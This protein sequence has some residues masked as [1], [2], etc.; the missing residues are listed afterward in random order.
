MTAQHGA[1]P[2]P[3]RVRVIR[4]GF[5]RSA[6]TGSLAPDVRDCLIGLATVADDMGWLIWSPGE[7]ATTL[8]AYQA[9]K[10]RLRDLERRAEQLA[11]AGLLVIHSCGCAFLPAMTAQHGMTSGRQTTPVW[12]WHHQHAGVRGIPGDA[13]E[14]PSSSSSSGSG[15]YEGSE[16]SSSPAR[17][18]SPPRHDEAS[19]EPARCLDCGR[20]TSIHAP[21]CPTVLY[22]A[23]AAVQ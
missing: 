18:G 22:P 12:N 2:A 7:V 6:T 10:R 14:R 4:P 15:S 23:L 8:Y 5:Y 13:V 21:T 20:P 17:D 19:G 9:P 16:S 3:S 1:P 11:A